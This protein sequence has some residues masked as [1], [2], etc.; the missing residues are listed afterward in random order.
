MAVLERLQYPF[1]FFAFYKE[2]TNIDPISYM[3]GINVAT[4]VTSTTPQDIMENAFAVNIVDS[5]LAIVQ[6]ERKYPKLLD[7]FISIGAR[8]V[9]N[10]LGPI[11]K[12]EYDY[13][14]NL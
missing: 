1:E 10:E 12:E 5:N 4:T 11:S 8:D 2:A 3:A 9:L 7:S 6:T 13:Y 14:E